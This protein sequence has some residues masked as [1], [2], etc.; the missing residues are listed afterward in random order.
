MIAIIEGFASNFIIGRTI[1]TIYGLKMGRG[2]VKLNNNCKHQIVEFKLS[3]SIESKQILSQE[4][5]NLML[6]NILILL[7]LTSMANAFATE[8][9]EEVA[10]QRKLE[11]LS[12]ISGPIDEPIATH[13]IFIFLDDSERTLKAVTQGLLSALI[14]KAGPILVSGS[15]MRNLYQMPGLDTLIKETQDQEQQKILKK[16]KN[17]LALLKREFATIDPR[18]PIETTLAELN[19]KLS[20]D[21]QIVQYLDAYANERTPKEVIKELWDY[22]LLGVQEND[23]AS[24]QVNDHLFLLIPKDYIQEHIKKFNPKH[25]LSG[26]LSQKELALG[27]R[28]DHMADIPGTWKDF[29]NKYQNPAQAGLVTYFVP[30]LK[31]IFISKSEYIDELRSGKEERSFKIYPTTDFPQWVF[32][33]TGHGFPNSSICALS[34]ADFHTLLKFFESQL[35]TRLFAYDSCYAMGIN[36]ELVY[37]DVVKDIYKSYPFIIAATGL[38]DVSATTVTF[39]VVSLYDFK[40]GMIS[41]SNKYLIVRHIPVRY[42]DFLR[43]ITTKWYPLNELLDIL[44][45]SKRADFLTTQFQIKY[46]GFEWFNI[47]NAQNRFDIIGRKLAFARTQPLNVMKFFGHKQEE[48][49]GLL[50]YASYIPFDLIINTSSM[51]LLIPMDKQK[52][53]DNN[54]ATICIFEKILST[55]LSADQILH[56]FKALYEVYG[57][58]LFYI[59]ELVSTKGSGLHDI[60][61]HIVAL[62]VKKPIHEM[63]YSQNGKKMRIDEKGNSVELDDTHR[64]TYN[65]ILE[66]MQEFQKSWKDAYTK[67][68]FQLEEMIARKRKEISSKPKIVNVKIRA[69]NQAARHII[70]LEIKSAVESIQKN[71]LSGNDKDKNREKLIDIATRV[72]QNFVQL[73]LQS[74]VQSSDAA[75]KELFKLLNQPPK[76]LKSESTKPQ[77]PEQEKKTEK[78][79]W[80]ADYDQVVA[81]M[82]AGDAK[83]AIKDILSKSLN[84]LIKNSDNQTLYQIAKQVA[85][86]LPKRVTDSADWKELIMYLNQ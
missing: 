23:W 83:G 28:I 63:Y 56:S 11:E 36:R 41:T 86:T 48:P 72:H 1:G 52:I 5:K 12:Q 43:K 13:G 79:A 3:V 70:H 80:N 29:F 66:L 71:G 25:K 69:I 53:A 15:L 8:K 40:K 18:K 16:I 32:Y 61:I 49:L 6:N 57:T 60:M 64:K 27:L 51:P 19:K 67:K 55:T 38:I 7:L 84:V 85:S 47:A 30:S 22:G 46:P 54:F 20:P 21:P 65:E 35:L 82:W 77:Q 31:N 34:I 33:L 10:E 75:W 76:Q 74:D 17:H 62:D 4:R 58:H 59:K 68:R 45:P 73:R 26:R 50:L 39:F 37:K 24:K 9:K 44:L 2:L 14:Q 78:N 42:G 81:L